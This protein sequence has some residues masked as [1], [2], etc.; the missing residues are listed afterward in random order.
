MLSRNQKR[1]PHYTENSYHAAYN[2]SIEQGTL[3]DSLGVPVPFKGNPLCHNF[4]HCLGN[5]EGCNHQQDEIN[6]LSKTKASEA[7]ISQSG[8]Q[9]AFINK[10]DY[11]G[12]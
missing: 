3:K 2:Y 7:F 5:A 9:G 8:R 10:S 6:I 1:G 11:L 4:R 12:D